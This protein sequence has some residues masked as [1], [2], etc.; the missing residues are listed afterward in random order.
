MVASN[1]PIVR[2][3][4]WTS[5]LT[6]ILVIT[7]FGLIA[8][9]VGLN[10]ILIYKGL[11]ANFVWGAVGQLCVWF[12]V[13]KTILRNHA[14]GMTLVKQKN[15][16]EAIPFFKNSIAILN[17]KPWLDKYR[18]FLGSSSKIS[19]KEMD[20]NNTAFC[21]SQI[22]DKTNAIFYYKKTLSEFP[23]SEMAKVALTF[24]DTM[25]KD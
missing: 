13:R 16:A 1:I 9:L 3:F 6:Q 20:L 2:Q 8:Y 18:Y 4:S 17:K 21:Y 19:Y 7:F 12:L 24:I 25:T 11:P 15:F 10:E 5:L 23:N 14:H 22:G